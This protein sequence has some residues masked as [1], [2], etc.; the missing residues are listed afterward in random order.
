MGHSASAPVHDIPS[1][2]CQLLV[3]WHEQLT[4]DPRRCRHQ[5]ISVPGCTH[6]CLQAKTTIQCSYFLNSGVHESMGGTRLRSTGGSM[7]GSLKRGG[8]Q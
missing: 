3:V 4:C 8:Q 1:L 5:P 6:A 7:G 2:A